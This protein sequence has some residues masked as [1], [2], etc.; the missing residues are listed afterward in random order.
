MQFKRDG[1]LQSSCSL[2]KV[3]ANSDVSKL[4]LVTPKKISV[5]PILPQSCATDLQLAFKSVM[6]YCDATSWHSLQA[7]KTFSSLSNN[8]CALDILKIQQLAPQ[9]DQLIAAIFHCA[10]SPNLPTLKPCT[11]CTCWKPVMLAAVKLQYVWSHVAECTYLL[12]IFTALIQMSL[13]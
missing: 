10:F 12:Q 5:L 4:K 8:G 9:N 7:S 2:R 13:T 1:A 3:N 11:L 6:N